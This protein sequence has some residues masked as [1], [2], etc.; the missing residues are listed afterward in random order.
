MQIL[1]LPVEVTY[2]EDVYIAKCPSIQGAF[3]EWETP[4]D[5]VKQL[6][7]VVEMIRDYRKES[8]ENYKVTT[9]KIFTSIPV[10]QYA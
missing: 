1:N 2:E 8:V 4:E 10:L 9:S 6:I 5:A 7:S 3:A